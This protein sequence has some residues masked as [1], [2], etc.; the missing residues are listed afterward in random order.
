LLDIGT[1][2]IKAGSTT[3]FG[4]GLYI[5]EKYLA[6]LDPLLQGWFADGGGLLAAV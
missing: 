3:R 2:A 1:A 4:A 6:R 5:L